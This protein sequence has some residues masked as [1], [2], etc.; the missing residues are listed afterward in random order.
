MDAK[1]LISFIKRLNELAKEKSMKAKIAIE[2]S[3]KQDN[4]YIGI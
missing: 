4:I 2:V 3:I 1:N